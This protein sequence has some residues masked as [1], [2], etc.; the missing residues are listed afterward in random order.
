MALMLSGCSTPIKNYL[1]MT[2]RPD[3]ANMYLV[4][5]FTW[6]EVDNKYQLVNEFGYRYVA[7]AQ[8]I[9]DGQP[10]EFKF[11]D[12]GWSAGTNCGYAFENKDKTLYE[13]QWVNANCFSGFENFQFTPEKSGKFRFVI[14]FQDSEY[15][16]VTVN[17]L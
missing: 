12:K 1:E 8:L 14:D 2:P 9:A 13:G 17:R 4:G 5:N 11:I 6:W 10:Y 15:P 7:D 16:R 3:Y